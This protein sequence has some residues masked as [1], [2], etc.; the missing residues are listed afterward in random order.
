MK[1]ISMKDFVLEQEK[2]AMSSQITDEQAHCRNVDYANSLNTPLTLGM[3]VPCGEDGKPLEEPEG[4]EFT[5]PDDNTPEME[6]YQQAKE[7]VYLWKC[8]V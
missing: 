1:L 5:H 2:L 8:Q 3:F 4:Y 7:R 6:Q